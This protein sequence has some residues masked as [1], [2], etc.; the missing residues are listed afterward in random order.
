[1]TDTTLQR[2]TRD[3]QRP[4]QRLDIPPDHNELVVRGTF[5]EKDAK[6]LEA[7]RAPLVSA[8]QMRETINT[9]VGSTANR[10]E[11]A[12]AAEARM[13]VV[14][15]SFDAAVPALEQRRAAVEA[16]ITKTL[17]GQ[18]DSH[19]LAICAHFK[20]AP[21]RFADASKLISSGD[22]RTA[23]ALL[24]APPY[25]SGL[26]PEQ[27]DALRTA[28]RVKF[29]PDQHG[30]SQDLER[31]I[32]TLKSVGSAVVK[33]V[34]GAIHTWGQADRDANAIKKALG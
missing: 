26:S 29:C 11:L 15:K 30:L 19:A 24:N 18:P 14:T 20:Q 6:L 8:R 7:A 22:A 5:I 9:L 31:A 17:A 1:M 33:Q 27:H 23:A 21:E 28:A 3:I 12:R 2:P 13:A 34:G 16:T 10:T 32:G 25:L 4:P